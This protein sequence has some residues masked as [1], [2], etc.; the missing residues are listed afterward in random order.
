MICMCHA[1]YQLRF[2]L[3]TNKIHHIHMYVNMWGVDTAHSSE[4]PFYLFPKHISCTHTNLT[5]IIYHWATKYFDCLYIG[6]CF[7]KKDKTIVLI[8]LPFLV[9]YLTTWKT[10]S[11]KMQQ[12]NNFIELLQNIFHIIIMHIKYIIQCICKL[13]N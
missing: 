8:K 9:P 7:G 5:R 6:T 3:Q 2:S 4:W 13:I 1:W 11:A 12:K 10:E